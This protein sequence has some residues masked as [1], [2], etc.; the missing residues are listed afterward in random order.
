VDP[1][2]HPTVV[3]PTP[4]EDQKVPARG[5]WLIISHGLHTGSS[6]IIC[7]G[8]PLP[9]CSLPG[10][11]VD[12]ISLDFSSSMIDECKAIKTLG[13]PRAMLDHMFASPAFLDQPVWLEFIQDQPV[14][15]IGPNVDQ[16]LGR[17][18]LDLSHDIP[19]L[20]PISAADPRLKLI[21]SQPPPG[22]GLFP[23]NAPLPEP[24]AACLLGIGALAILRRR[25]RMAE[26][27]R[28]SPKKD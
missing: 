19:A 25:R 14:F 17:Y 9:A 11:V 8:G 2:V 10:S 22:Q 18:L 3:T 16:P 20:I 27:P 4:G 15:Y 23:S 5:P 24:S 12:G 26:A 7:S 28:P 13:V 21:V 1:I 6:D